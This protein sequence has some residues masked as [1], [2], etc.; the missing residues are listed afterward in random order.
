MSP[1]LQMNSARR[2]YTVRAWQRAFYILVG[3]GLLAVGI[4]LF[5]VTG[6]ASDRLLISL[7][8]AVFPAAGIYMLA[9]A[10][11]ARLVIDG[12]RI[13]V[14]GAFQERSARIDEIEGFRTISSRNGAYK[15]LRLKDG[16][17]SI[18][19]SSYY[20]TDDDYKAWLQQ[21]PDLDIRDRDA[22]L[23]KIS[24]ESELGATPEERLAA[25]SRAKTWSIAAIVISGAAAAALNFGGA[26]LQLPS[27][28]VLA[29]TP[30]AAVFLAGRSPLL[31][32][33][34]RRKSDPRA[35]FTLTLAFSSFGLLFRAMDFYV[36]STQSLLMVA[37]AFAV[38]YIA[39]LYTAANRGSSVPGSLIA[40]LFFAA[41][42]GYSLALVADAVADSAPGQIYAT[43]VIRK[44]VSRGRSTTWYLDLAPWGPLEQPN[45]IKVSSSMYANTPIGDEVCL[46]L[47]PGAFH[48][49][50]YQRA[51]CAP[52]SVPPPAP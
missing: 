6:S 25:L 20:A 3:I 31:F 8:S 44:H 34:F 10:T 27:A 49:S 38:L 18:T 36:V 14:R 28:I 5:T 9:W 47:H 33:I 12:D 41:I 39:A 7:V 32:T 29:L 30:F 22:L 35:D 42:Y 40:V 43:Q 50:W 37:A 19:L 24:H 2:E 13:E 11:R 17:G 1:S 51:D 52:L 26:A 21:F 46:A 23:D 48:V 45:K 15:Q 4:F 16:R